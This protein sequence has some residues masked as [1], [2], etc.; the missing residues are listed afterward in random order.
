MNSAPTEPILEVNLSAICRN[1]RRLRTLASGGAIGAVVKSDSYGL[2]AVPITK[3][4]ADAGARHFFTATITEATE[5]LESLP[6][7]DH[8]TI[9][10]FGG[11][12][13]DEFPTFQADPRLTPILN[14]PAH[15]AL[16]RESRPDNRPAFI[17]IDTGMNRLGLG[18]DLWREIRPSLDFPVAGVLSHLVDADALSPVH[19]QQQRRL[20]LDLSE[21]NRH[22]LANSAGLFLGSDFHGGLAR[23]GIALYGASP[24]PD[25][26][27]LDLGLEPCVRLD[28]PILQTRP[29]SP[30]DTIGYGALFTC[31][32]PM[33]VGTVGIGYN[34]GIPRSLTGND[35]FQIWIEQTPTPVLGRISMDTLVIDLSHCPNADEN[36][37]VD[38]INDRQR[39][40][41]IAKRCDTLPHEV[42]TRLKGRI[43]RKYLTL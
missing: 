16:W 7:L 26:T 11:F 43:V 25:R 12:A 4:L 38:V 36:T 17:Q 34:D 8:L 29:L 39:L 23:P 9:A 10:S 24:F 20:L 22:S 40:E 3:A 37:R 32:R 33:R 35:Q 21:G 27:S 30:G 1:W 13:A 42:L 19:A 28:A 2:G 31:P 6:D 18:C 15:I 41:E 14:T 5:I